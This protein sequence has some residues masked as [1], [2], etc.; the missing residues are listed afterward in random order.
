SLNVEALYALLPAAPRVPWRHVAGFCGRTLGPVY[1][2][3]HEDLE[4]AAP[5]FA[6]LEFDAVC[7]R[8]RLFVMWESLIDRRSLTIYSTSPSKLCPS[9]VRIMSLKTCASPRRQWYVTPPETALVIKNADPSVPTIVITPCADQ[10][11]ESSCWVPFQDACFGDRL[12][13]PAHP[14]ANA[15]HPPLRAAPLPGPRRWEWANG[16]WRAVL[17]SVDEQVRRGWF[18]RARGAHRR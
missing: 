10:P 12:V 11:R 9:L 18:S 5:Y 2:A 16:H 6:Q 17:P 13:V 8:Q 4:N 15:V 7:H 3:L 1:K 14:V